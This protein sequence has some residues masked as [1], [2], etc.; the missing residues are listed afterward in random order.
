MANSDGYYEAL[1]PRSPRQT[2]GKALPKRGRPARQREARARGRAAAALQGTGRRRRH[3]R[4][5]VLRELHARRVA[6]ERGGR[7]G[8]GVFF[9]PGG[10][11]RLW[12][13]RRLLGA[14]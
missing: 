2:R 7:G 1:W 8:G 5:G 13:R 11:G 12:P 4:D 3:I 9:P 6:G 10:R 14:P